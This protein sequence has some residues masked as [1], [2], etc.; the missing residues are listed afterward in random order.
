MFMIQPSH[1]ILQ[2]SRAVFRASSIP[3]DGHNHNNALTLWLKL[4]GFFFFRYVYV[5]GR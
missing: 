2:A 1:I 5:F 4:Q 3:E